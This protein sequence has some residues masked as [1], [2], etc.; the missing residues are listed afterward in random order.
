MQQLI[1]I[2]V[3]NLALLFPHVFAGAQNERA[4][5]ASLPEYEVINPVIREALDSLSQRTKSCVFCILDKP[6]FYWLR[7]INQKDTAIRIVFES[8]QYSPNLLAF[9]LKSAKEKGFFYHNNV[10]VIAQGDHN[11]SDFLKLK[12]DSLHELLY[13]PEFI[14]SPWY[15]KGYE[16]ATLVYRYTGGE[17]IMQTEGE[18]NLLTYLH[19]KVSESDTWESLS[20]ECRCPVETLEHVDGEYV[21]TLP[22]IGEYIIIRYEICTDKEVV[23]SRISQET[24]F[25]MDKKKKKRKR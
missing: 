1:N 20:Y 6:Y 17:L 14:I 24:L 15:L 12:N 16:A 13:R 5:L 18:C 10:L 22:E 8:L 23:V 11:L 4:H 25:G 3:L 21:G 2:T 19:E 9:S 7:V